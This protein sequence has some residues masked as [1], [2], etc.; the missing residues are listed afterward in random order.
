MACAALRPSLVTA[1]CA[2]RAACVDLG[3]L[4][5]EFTRAGAFDGWGARDDPLAWLKLGR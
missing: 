3:P 5:A 1:D 4:V 2:P